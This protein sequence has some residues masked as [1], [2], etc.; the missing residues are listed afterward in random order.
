MWS[1]GVTWSFYNECDRDL[2]DKFWW[3]SMGEPRGVRIGKVL[4]D[5]N[6]Q[7]GQI[8]ETQVGWDR[9]RQRNLCLW[10]S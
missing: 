7:R 2:G 5:A 6:T 4:H 1:Y 10:S 3:K 9:T 8:H